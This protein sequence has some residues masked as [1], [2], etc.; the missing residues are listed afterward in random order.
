MR[1]IQGQNRNQI[2]MFS[3]E[4]MVEKDAFVRVI[5]AFVDML[6]LETFGFS[7][8]TLNK[9]GRPTFHPPL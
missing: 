5:D 7:Y 8:F 9:E 4:Q 6:D 3:L 1:H 2:R